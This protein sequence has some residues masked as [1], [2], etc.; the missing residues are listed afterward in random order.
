MKHKAQEEAM[1][2]LHQVLNVKEFDLYAN[3]KPISQRG[4]SLGMLKMWQQHVEMIFLFEVVMVYEHFR[5]YTKCGL[6]W[7]L[8]MGLRNKKF[9]IKLVSQKQENYFNAGIILS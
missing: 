1:S 8:T 6:L 4:E 2:R 7:E 5:V 9:G 3:R